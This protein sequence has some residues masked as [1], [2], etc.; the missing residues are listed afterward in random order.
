MYIG[1]DVEES[2]IAK[3]IVAVFEEKRGVG[4]FAL[5][6][7]ANKGC[8]EIARFHFG[9]FVTYFCLKYTARP[10]EPTIPCN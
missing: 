9:N 7:A 6:K 3:P 5:Y 2:T 1:E 4:I 8:C 10:A